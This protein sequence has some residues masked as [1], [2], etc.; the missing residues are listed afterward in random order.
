MHD[1]VKYPTLIFVDLPLVYLTV[2]ISI[3]SLCEDRPDIVPNYNTK[4]EKSFPVLKIPIF[5]NVEKLN[6]LRIEKGK[7]P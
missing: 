7:S 2:M 1:E 5:F 4:D 3:D 6:H